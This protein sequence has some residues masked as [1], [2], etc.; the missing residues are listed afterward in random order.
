MIP[1]DILAKAKTMEAVERS[2]NVRDCGEQRTDETQEIFRPVK[3]DICHYTFVHIYSIYMGFPGGSDSKKYP[4]AMWETWIDP[5][6]GKIFWR[7]ER[8][9]TPVFLPGQIHGQRSQAGYSPW[10]GRIRHD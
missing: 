2:M 9:P 4:P 5:W 1:Y 6:F 10:S 3:I 8:L 7:S